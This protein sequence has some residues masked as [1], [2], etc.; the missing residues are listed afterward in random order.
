MQGMQAGS[1]PVRVAVM[2]A[3]GY[4]G[5]EALRLLLSH[6]CVEVAA[7]TS[8]SHA[9]KP[10][11]D[12][13]PHLSKLTDLHFTADISTEEAVGFDAIFMALPHGAAMQRVPEILGA[14]DKGGPHG[15]GPVLLD[16]SG[17]FRIKD[18]VQFAKFYGLEHTAN[19]L[20]V[21]AAYGL[22]EWNRE[23]IMEARLVACPGCFPTGALLAL[24]PLA[25]AGLLE[26]PVVIDSKTGS[27][28]S[29]KEPGE[30][31][32]HP[33]RSQDFRA[34]NLL[35]H[36]HQ[37][38]IAQELA[39]WQGDGA[40]SMRV[41]FTPH[42]APMIRGIFTTAY[43]FPSR[44]VSKSELQDIYREA[45]EQEHFVRLVDNPRVAV[46]THSNFCDIAATTDGEGTIIVTSAIDNLV[47]GG[48]GQAVQDLNV[49]FGWPE[50]LGLTFPGTMP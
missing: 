40:N 33:V 10:V 7:V 36:R 32:H 12:V 28:G 26:G 1:N 43:V 48:A 29:G 25:R 11:T 6:P 34:Y 37:P 41:V 18:A 35:K 20:A 15:N 24:T 50:K 38:E 21:S 31:T 16:M 23:A 22:T 2:G 17:D 30:G 9:G 45:Y 27:S 4:I 8:P 19:E 39:K 14:G 47:K 46:V 3:S 44:P 5:G 49:A 13:L 42:S